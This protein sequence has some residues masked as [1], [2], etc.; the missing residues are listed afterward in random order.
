MGRN[1][2]GLFLIILGC[3][4][5]FA[6][7]A[8]YVYND[9]ISSRAAAEAAD[10]TALL[11][12][13]MT[14]DTEADTQ[15]EDPALPEPQADAQAET[16]APDSVKVKNYDIIGVLS[17]P[18]IDIRLPVISQWSYP[19]LR[20]APCRYS[21]DPEGQLI[22]LA[23]NY[24]RHF[25]HIKDLEAGDTVGFTAVDGTVYSYQVTETEI[26]DGEKGLGDITAGS[27]WNLTLF[28]CTYGGASRVVVRCTK[29]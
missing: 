18:A 8:L 5:V 11:E 2:T 19:N 4:C 20:A 17:I 23:H 22:L 12:Q 6:A 3:C 10:L 14:S 25:G 29:T 15:E 26:V 7:A 9:R 28:T 16:D 27:D 24:A 1:K 13:T 21:G